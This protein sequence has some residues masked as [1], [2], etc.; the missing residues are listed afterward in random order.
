M[1]IKPKKKY[2]QNFLKSK[3]IAR[4]IV[5]F[6]H[7][8]NEDK[9]IEIGPGQGILTDFIIE[10]NP[11]ALYLF[12]I[13]DQVIELCKKKYRSSNIYIEKK[14][15][16]KI[17]YKNIGI[18]LKVISNLPYSSYSLILESFIKAR[19]YIKIGVFMFQKEVAENI[20]YRESWLGN[21][22]QTFFQIKYEMSVPG[23]F[24]YPVPKVS[25]GVLSFYKKEEIPNIKDDDKYISF[26]KKLS[27]GKNKIIRNKFNNV[28]LE[29]SNKRV[30]ELSLEEIIKLFTLL[31]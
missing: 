7:I 4:N 17:D 2:S 26:L 19:N 5:E 12:D 20:L 10:K 16:S 21:Y 18:E 9:I 13:D 8:N 28:P 27:K 3:D 6:L 15:G 24:F 25:S 11:K 23:R 31:T 22:A 29:F 30:H 1:Y 14:D